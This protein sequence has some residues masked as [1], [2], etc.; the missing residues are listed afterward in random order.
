MISAVALAK[1][2][3]QFRAPITSVLPPNFSVRIYSNG[4]NY[5]LKKFTSDRPQAVHVKEALGRTLWGIKFASPI[6]NAAGMFKNGEGYEVCALQ[7]AGA[8]LAGTTTSTVRKGNLRDGVLSPF[9]PYPKSQ[10][11]SNWL[12][13]PNEGNLEIA[14]RLKSIQRVGACPIGAS[15]A[16]APEL[17]GEERLQSLV[18]GMLAY[19]ES[20][21]D[22][23]EMNESCPNTEGVAL[24]E[25]D[26]KRRL[27]FL[28]DKFLIKRDRLLPVIVKFST[29][30]LPSQVRELVSIVIEL[31]FDGINFGNTSTNYQKHR[32]Q[33]AQ[34]ELPLYDYFTGKFGGGVSGAPLNADSLALVKA[35]KNAV[36]EL[37]PKHE[38]HII[39]TGGVSSAIDIKESIE[40]GAS[41][42]QWYSAY[43]EE[44]SKHGHQLY[45]KLYASL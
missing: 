17:E 13:L 39:R 21:V 10:A 36:K 34:A 16:A 29:D 7:G 42:V 25:D 3:K 30:T 28:R 23:I 11:A 5:F 19:Q 38:F 27:E 14:K 24:K 37:N 12:G 32:S 41:L 43:F 40:A 44:F 15:I 31:G 26:L 4:R 6:F 18:D 2:D 35:A 20:N 22:F 9:V 1:I 45:E 8:Y 33:I